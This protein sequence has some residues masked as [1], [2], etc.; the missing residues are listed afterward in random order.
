MQGDFWAEA[1]IIPHPI[2]EIE[3]QESPKVS[4]P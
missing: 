3:T 4:M 1:I 2:L